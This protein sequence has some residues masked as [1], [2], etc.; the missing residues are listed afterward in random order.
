MPVPGTEEMVRS[1]PRRPV[2]FF[3]LVQP[4]PGGFFIVAAVAAGESFFKYARQILTADADAVVGN[5]QAAAVFENPDAAAGMRVF[6]RV[7]QKLLDHEREPFS[8]VN[9][10]MPVG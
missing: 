5:H 4:D 1:W 8:S 10:V 3:A 6:Q 2:I 7:G 9:T